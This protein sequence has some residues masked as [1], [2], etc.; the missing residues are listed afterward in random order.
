MKYLRRLIGILLI[1]LAAGIY[2]NQQY[3]FI[4]RYHTWRQLPTKVETKT[5]VTDNPYLGEIQRWKA[6]NPEVV[7]WLKIPDVLEVPVVQG[8]NNEFYLTH[9]AT[10]RENING[11]V[12]LDY[13]TPVKYSDNVV[14]YGHNMENKQAFSDLAKY[15]K[16]DF[17]K[18]HLTMTLATE[19][20]LWQGEVMAVCD[21]NLQN[22]QEYF[23]FNSWL[24][25][26]DDYDANSYFKG[27]EPS[28]RLKLNSP[29]KADEKI[30]TLS[31]CDNAQPD[32]RILVVAKLT[33]DTASK[34]DE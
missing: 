4:G 32:A 30:L 2:L 3:D 7:A 21:M 28:M 15:L 24:K 29:S 23:N 16:A 12:F 26:R 5:T 18:K 9:D 6:V 13:E 20:T 10:R 19:D 34:K 1:L 14:I 17:A 25:W 22:K 31:T 33:Q 8:K 11:A 27:L